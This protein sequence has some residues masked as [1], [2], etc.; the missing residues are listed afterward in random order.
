MAIGWPK[1]WRRLGVGQRLVE[2]RLADAER[3]R[4]DGDAAALEGQAGQR[5]ALAGRAEQLIGI[6]ADVGEVEVH[7]AEAADA[8]RIGAGAAR[9]PLGVAG[10]DERA[11]AAAGDVGLG[12]AE[13]D[14]QIGRGRVGHPHLLPDQPEAERRRA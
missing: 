13:D 4:R 12:G 8:E 7:A 9:D 11:D 3:L 14:Q 1:V 10:H 5:E 2:R 6:D